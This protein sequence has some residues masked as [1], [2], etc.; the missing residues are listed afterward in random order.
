MIILKKILK[1]NWAF[2][3]RRFIYRINRFL[4]I[5]CLALSIN[6]FVSRNYEGINMT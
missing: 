3:Q 5:D 6:Y 1:L 4:G 2:T